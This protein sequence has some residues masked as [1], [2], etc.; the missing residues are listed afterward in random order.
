MDCNKINLKDQLTKIDK[1]DIDN[2]EI[3]LDIILDYYCC[4]GSLQDFTKEDFEVAD[5]YGFN[6]ED[7]KYFCFED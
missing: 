4:I 3:I 5:E 6:Y 2:A 7:L 1:D